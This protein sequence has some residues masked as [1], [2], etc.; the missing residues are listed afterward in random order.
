MDKF[1]SKITKR[2]C[3]SIHYLVWNVVHLVTS[4]KRIGPI[5]HI[6]TCTRA[7]AAKCEAQGKAEEIES[8]EVQLSFRETRFTEE[9]QFL[10]S[11]IRM[12]QVSF[13]N[14]TTD[15]SHQILFFPEAGM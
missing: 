13:C 8:R 3:T 2:K 10:E 9:K 15:C 11:Q 1:S 7:T 4:V 6:L 14:L 12:L 5:I